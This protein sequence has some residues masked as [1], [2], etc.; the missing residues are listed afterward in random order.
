MPYFLTAILLVNIHREGGGTG[1]N[2]TFFRPSVYFVMAF[3]VWPAY[4]WYKGENV[5]NDG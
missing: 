5:L 4:Y 2:M 3:F 1:K